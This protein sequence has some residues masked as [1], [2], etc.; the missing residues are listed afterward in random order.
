MNQIHG[1]DRCLSMTSTGFIQYNF[2]WFN[3]DYKST[4]ELPDVFRY[5]LFSLFTGLNLIFHLS[6][7]LSFVWPRYKLSTISI[8][9]NHEELLFIF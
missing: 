4:N 8:S 1:T 2:H 9:F 5:D 3:L 6:L 7:T